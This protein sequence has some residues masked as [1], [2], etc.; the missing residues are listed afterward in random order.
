MP[1]ARHHAGRRSPLPALL[2]LLVAVM[3]VGPLGASAAPNSPARPESGSPIA[4]P[5]VS[6]KS[7]Y[8]FDMTSGIELYSKD[9]KEHLQVGSIVKIATALVVMENAQLDEQVK[10]VESDLVDVNV[11]SNMALVKGDTL[12]VSQLLYG[13][14]IPS[15]NDGARAL[16]R[17]VGAKLSG[18]EDPNTA[19][20]AF[21]K[22]MNAYAADLGLKDTRFTVPDGIDTPN[23]YSCAHDVAILGAELMK[24]EF[25]AGVVREPGYSFVSVGPEQRQYQ[26]ATTNLRLNVNG[27][28]GVKT[29]TTDQA[30]A[31]VVL[32]R[33]VNGGGNTVIMAIVGADPTTNAAGED[34]RWGDADTIVANMDQTFTWATP[35]TA[36][37]LPGLAE[38]MSI[39]DVQFQ[40]P[41][42]V[43]VPSGEVTLGYQLQVGPPADPGKQVGS[44][45]LYFG[46]AE[47]GRIPI[48]QAGEQA[49]APALRLA[50]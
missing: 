17:H 39:W 46:D 15:G 1:F 14:L 40:N 35:D 33:Q 3:L 50:A 30:G 11:Y 9:P 27:I 32:A 22:A 12:T 38:Q 18:S 49:S 7:V 31:N 36:D 2:A 24:N 37:L 45:H 28:V 43:P 6:A 47:V 13:L 21:V 44:V 34:G 5:D 25:L 29:G 10:I 20:D 42:A 48:Y 8:V 23:S 26:K 16:A 41:P 4:P 19:M